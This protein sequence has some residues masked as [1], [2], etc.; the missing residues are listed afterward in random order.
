MSL[1]YAHSSHLR[2]FWGTILLTSSFQ[3]VFKG[4]NDSLHSKRSYSVFGRKPGQAA[5]QDKITDKGEKQ[6]NPKKPTRRQDSKSLNSPHLSSTV[7]YHDD[8]DDD[9]DDNDDNN[10]DDAGGGGDDDVDI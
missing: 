8:D 9:D 1:A 3:L 7:V 2:I 6:V 5:R 4:W 10:D